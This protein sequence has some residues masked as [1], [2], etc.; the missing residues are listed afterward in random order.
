MD[1]I[2]RRDVLTIGAAG[3]AL[4]G[5]PVASAQA[6]GEAG[7]QTGAPPKFLILAC[8]GG[9]IRGYLTALIVERLNK[10]VPFIDRVNLFAGTSTGSILAIGLA[11]GLSPASLVKLYRDEGE[12]IFD[13]TR[14]K[15]DPSGRIGK[16]WEVLKDHAPAIHE[17]LGFHF[18]DLLRARYPKEGL[19]SALTGMLGDATFRDLK[20]G[21]AAMVTTLRL[22][23]DQKSWV[24][25]VLHNLDVPG[26]AGAAHLADG[27]TLDTRLV[28]AVMC[29][30]AAPLYF[31]P[32]KHPEFGYC[33]DGGLFANCPASIALALADR[34]NADKQVAVRALSI[35]TGAQS[36]HIEIPSSPFEKPE[37]YGA[38]AWLL[39]LTRGRDRSGDDRTP[40]FPLVSALFDASSASHNYI[41]KQALGDDYH[42]VQ[43]HL[44]QAIPLD[45]T[46]PLSMVRIEQAA[47]ALFQS[48]E[49]KST[50]VWLRGQLS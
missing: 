12:K 30:S 16:F 44:S 6:S 25:L 36:N 1:Q 21:K 34:A 29:S 20:P 24:P 23:S 18:I 11:H 27:P 5:A 47:G 17:H 2:S 42:R 22:S 7:Q 28:D 9:G 13:R 8:D 14:P 33:V 37:E 48:D 3:V 32:H 35:G 41:C 15:P 31:P 43:V 45:S 10:E 4:S 49:W 26:A 46:D 38:L 40:A 19:Q 39:P 50:Q